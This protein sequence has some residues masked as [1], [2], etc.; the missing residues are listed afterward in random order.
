MNPG[1]TIEDTETLWPLLALTAFFVGALPI[2]ARS[3]RR[4]N[5]PRDERIEQRRTG[6]FLGRYLMYYLL[7]VI[8]PIERMLIRRRVSPN[9]LTFCSLLLSVAAAVAIG[10]GRFGIGGWLYLFTGIFDIFDGRVARATQRVT[11]AGAFYD[12]VVDRWAEAFIFGGLA[13]LLP[14]PRG[15]WRWCSWRRRRRS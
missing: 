10:A 6:P 13:V 4:G 1:L 8:G 2:Y 11:R 3:V 15:R 5:V 12:S 7:W 14:L 9:L